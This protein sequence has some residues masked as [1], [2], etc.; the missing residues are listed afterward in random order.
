MPFSDAEKAE[1]LF[2]LGYSGFEDDGPAM[3]AIHSLDP[4]EKTLGPRVRMILDRLRQIECDIHGSKDLAVAVSTGGGV[5]TRA[6][7][8]LDHLWRMGRS[9]VGQLAGWIK[10]M[11]YSDVFSSGAKT[12]NPGFYS[13]DPSERRIDSS[14]GVPT[15]SAHTDRGH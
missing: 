4:K 9:Y 10:V 15:D 8:T 12:R 5:Q 1:M 3:R 13:G 2:Y 11:V 14:E 7:Y 6:H